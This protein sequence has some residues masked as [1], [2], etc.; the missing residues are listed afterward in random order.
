M[1][2][3]QYIGSKVRTGRKNLGLTQE[4]L[5]ERIDKAVETISNIERGHAY[6]GLETLEKIGRVLEVPVRDF[7]EEV[8]AVRDVSIERLELEQRVRE[9]IRSLS[10]DDL[11][12][13]VDQIELIAKHR[14]G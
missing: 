3:K 10:D 12:M 4:Q 9:L 13:A 5:A 6:T 1:D 8:E 14:Q 2:M 7:F 11:K